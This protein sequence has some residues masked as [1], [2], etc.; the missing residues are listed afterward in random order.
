MTNVGDQLICIETASPKTK[1]AEPRKCTTVGTRIPRY[2]ECCESVTFDW[3][4]WNIWS[5]LQFSSMIDDVLSFQRFP[6]SSLQFSPPFSLPFNPSIFNFSLLKFHSKFLSSGIFFFC[7]RDIRWENLYRA[8]SLMQNLRNI[9]L[10]GRV[11]GVNMLIF[12][13]MFYL[14]FLF[15]Q[16]FCEERIS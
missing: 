10:W 3:L 5:T 16:H 6:L 11:E 9:V 1:N 14:L 15:R 2:S 13:I 7:L 8:E 4:F 12:C